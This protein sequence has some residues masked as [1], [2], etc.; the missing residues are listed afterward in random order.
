MISQHKLTALPT[1]AAACEMILDLAPTLQLEV[2][3]VV[4]Q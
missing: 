1:H 2:N 4:G 3:T